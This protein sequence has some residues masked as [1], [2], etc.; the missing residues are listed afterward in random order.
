MGHSSRS[1]DLGIMP[2]KG[3]A[4]MGRKDVFYE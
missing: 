3:C 1:K 4:S 2:P